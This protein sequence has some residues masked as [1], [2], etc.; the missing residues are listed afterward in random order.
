[1]GA[2]V[3]YRLR[4]LGQFGL[5]RGVWLDCGCGDGGYTAALQREGVEHVIGVDVEAVRL[6]RAQASSCGS[7]VLSYCCAESEHLP[8]REASFDGV[9]LNEV[10]EH[11]MDEAATLRE[12]YR[13][14]C[15]GG[16]L[17]LMSPN[18]WF[19]F[20]GHGMQ[21]ANVP[22]NIPVPLLP[23]LPKRLV[24]RFMKARNYWPSE[25]RDMVLREGFEIL[26]CS[27][28]FPVFEVYRWLPAF[29]TR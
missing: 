7:S 29:F 28:V 25:L 13:V 26:A 11:V 3:D 12:I 24:M 14:L 22:I 9:F 1:V 2:N 5:L 4:K 19:P 6:T 23:W 8:F 27:S 18:R 16:V 17:A 20:E 10:L 21:V 15:P